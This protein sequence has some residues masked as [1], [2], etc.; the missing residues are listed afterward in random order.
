MDQKY[1]KK[2]FVLE[3]LGILLGLL[4]LIPFYFVAI[5][6]VKALVKYWWMQLHS[7]QKYCSAT[8]LRYGRLSNFLERFGTRL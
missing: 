5:N 1:T 7:Q 6:S 2:T 4:F 3:V 8:T